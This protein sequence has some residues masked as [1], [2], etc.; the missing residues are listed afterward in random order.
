[1]NTKIF[2][3]EISAA[4]TIIKDGGIVAVP[5]ETVY[6]LAAN[7]LNNQ[8]VERIFAVKGRPENKPLSLM[9]EGA[10][11]IDLLCENVPAA[12][13][14]LAECYW[15]GPL[16][17]VLK[18]KPGIPEAVRAGGNTVGLRCPKHPKT[19]ELLKETNLPLAAPSAN[20]SGKES[21]KTAE[22]VFEYFSGL[23]EGIIDGGECELGLESTVLDMS[24]TPYTV[25]RQGA[26][27]ESE[28]EMMLMAGLTIIG[29]TGGTGCG[30][31]TALDTLRD[32]GGLVIDC[33]AVYHEL[34]RD[35]EALRADIDRRFPGVFP[36]GS[37]DTKD[38]GAI[39]FSDEKALADLNA[40]THKF[41]GIE[42]TKRLSDWAKNAGTLVAID[43]IAL[44]ESGV[45]NI[46]KATVGITAPTDKRISRL[47]KRENITKEY[48]Q[49]RIAAQKPNEY[50]EDV[51]DYTVSNDSTIENFSEK[52][53]S[54][55]SE[56]IGR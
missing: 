55:F 53:R 54:V 52:C 44:V 7:G 14:A 31:T 38:L 21:A 43:A 35:S 32:M 12:A 47:M 27:A 10:S 30:K 22:K 5:T 36:Q 29:I 26:V 13:F 34:L 37:I 25:L 4:A 24:K 11:A 23:I 33:D 2:D 9:V 51:C 45:G 16:T 17:I 20:P 56:I 41:V 1:M 15:P 49:L 19:L 42:M 18:A 46:C 39:V 6:G 8:A 48:A 28:I 50:F 40:I 3:N